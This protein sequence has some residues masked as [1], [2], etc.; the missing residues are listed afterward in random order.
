MNISSYELAHEKHTSNHYV[1]TNHVTKM[2]SKYTESPLHR[3][4]CKDGAG[5]AF[6]TLLDQ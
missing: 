4:R 3:Q 6:S 2:K 5:G 1:I